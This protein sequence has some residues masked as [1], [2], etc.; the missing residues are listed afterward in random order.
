MSIIEDGI[1]HQRTETQTKKKG[2]YIP[3][4]NID[5]SSNNNKNNDDNNIS[6]GFDENNN[7]NVDNENNK[8]NN[9]SNSNS[10]NHIDS[11]IPKSSLESKT[12]T[13]LAPEP[14]ELQPG[15]NF[16]NVLRTTFLYVSLFGSFSLVT[17]G[18]VIFGAKIL[19]EKRLPKTLMKLTEGNSKRFT[20][21][22]FS[23]EN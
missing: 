12:R 8:N 14:P 18:F 3:Q 7:Q 4:T 15:V 2:S 17:F 22:K 23:L 9:N 21:D 16:I 20:E 11:D 5:N 6:I 19:Y 1:C 13:R 10:N